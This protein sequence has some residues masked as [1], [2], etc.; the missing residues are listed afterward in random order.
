M[1]FLDK[2]RKRKEEPTS[3]SV[4]TA[5]YA[6]QPF[7]LTVSATKDGRSQLEFVDHQS[8]DLKQFYDV[9]RLIIN[10]NPINVNGH[11][12]Y[13]CDI[14]WYGSTDAIY[15]GPRGEELGRRNDFKNILTEIDMGR[16]QTDR[17]Y[18]QYVMRQLLNRKRVL[19]YLEKGLTDSPDIPCGKYVGGVRYLENGNLEKFFS[20]DV[21]KI[22]HSSSEMKSM[23]A[24]HRSEQEAKR[25]RQIAKNRA[26][27]Q[28]LQSEINHL[29]D[30]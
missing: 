15:F 23:R 27:I 14:A 7:E 17:N 21:G 8:D 3:Y 20:V 29:S 28:R 5:P 18:C 16:I 4:P 30:R 10:G 22:A 24:M 19:S 9:T 26:E 13:D 6:K 11:T 2:F 25:A 12:V 1:G